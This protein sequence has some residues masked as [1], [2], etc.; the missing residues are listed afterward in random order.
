M[1]GVEP[2]EEDGEGLEREIGGGRD[3][4]DSVEVESTSSKM[5]SAISFSW[6]SE[7]SA[8]RLFS[9]FSCTLFSVPSEVSSDVSSCLDSRGWRNRIAEGSTET[10]SPGAMR[11]FAFVC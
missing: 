9:E 10:I 2:E 8:S 4:V 7:S 3:S 5:R 11:V 6:G 1:V